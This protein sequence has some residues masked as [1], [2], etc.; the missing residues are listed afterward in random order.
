ANI[1]DI[2]DEELDEEIVMAKWARRGAQEQVKYPVR[3]HKEKGGMGM[4]TEQPTKKRRLNPRHGSEIE[5]VEKEP[6]SPGQTQSADLIDKPREEDTIGSIAGEVVQQNLQNNNEAR[7]YRAHARK[8]EEELKETK[9]R[10]ES[11]IETLKERVVHNEPKLLK[12]NFLFPDELIED[13]KQ[14]DIWRIVANIEGHHNTM[15]RENN[16]NSCSTE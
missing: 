11:R 7:V 2:T 3:V 16:P 14:L 4:P 1:E 8:F 12:D 13:L 9:W 5:L 6:Q 10:I 15:N